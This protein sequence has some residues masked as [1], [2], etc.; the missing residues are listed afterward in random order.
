VIGRA[1]WAWL[2]VVASVGGCTDSKGDDPVDDTETEDP[3]VD[4]TDTIETDVE[5]DDTDPV[6]DD[7]DTTPIDTEPDDTDT[8]LVDTDT[9]PVDTDTTPVDTDTTP[10][11]TDTTPVDTDTTPVD[12]DTTAVDTDTTPVDTDTTPVDTDTTPVDTDTTPIDTAANVSVIEQIQRG[13]IPPGTFVEFEGP[14]VTATLEDSV[15]ISEPDGDVYRAVH[16]FSGQPAAS[17]LFIDAVV[18]IAGRV[19]EVSSPSGSLT[20]INTTV[21]GGY[22]AE[23]LATNAPRGLD[24]SLDELVDPVSAE[25]YEGVLVHIRNPRVWESDGV[26]RLT[27]GDADGDLVVSTQEYYPGALNYGDRI[28]DLTGVLHWQNDR[29]ELIPRRASDYQVIL[30]LLN[31]AD[32]L[33]EGDLVLT[34]WMVEPTSAGCAT[35]GTSGEYVEVLNTTGSTVDLDGLIIFNFDTNQQVVQRGRLEVAS[36]ARAVIFADGADNCYGLPG[37]T[38]LGWYQSLSTF[39][40]GVFNPVV[41]VDAVVSFFWN[42][43]TGASFE[44]SE[45]QLVHTANDVE[46]AWCPASATIPGSTDLGTPGAVNSC[47]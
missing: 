39:G 2:W 11:D 30:Q 42:L 5:P 1:G 45:S 35:P 15:F 9:T 37:D 24:V 18:A 41:A 29:F 10:V 25:P 16:V 13:R 31:P 27:I 43:P 19:E 32:Q 7:T 36:G 17:V 28:G 8:T 38:R 3:A 6:I 44:L 4:D 40:I 12:T 47:P 23:I 21:P 26:S 34:E 20:R 14:V 46:S 33:Q 22:I